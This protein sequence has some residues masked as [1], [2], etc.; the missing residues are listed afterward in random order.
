M[1]MSEKSK[2]FNIE[3]QSQKVPEKFK[4]IVNA[5]NSKD[6][7]IVEGDRTYVITNKVLGTGGNGIVFK[8]ETMAI[9]SIQLA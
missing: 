4:N 9:K 7:T 3:N 1:L 6:I 2:Q 5:V 8:G